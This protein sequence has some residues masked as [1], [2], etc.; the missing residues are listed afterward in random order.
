[1]NVVTGSTNNETLMIK[2]IQSAIGALADGM[3]GTQTMSDIACKFNA[4]CFPLTLEI[5]KKPVIIANDI[6]PIIKP[7]TGLS[8]FTNSINGS[9]T[10]GDGTPNSICVVDGI[11]KSSNASHAHYGY[12]E[13]VLYKTYDGIVDIKRVKSVTELP[14][15]I[16]WAVGGM[17]LQRFYDPNAEGF[18]LMPDGKRFDDV[19]RLTNHAMLGYKNNY[20]F[21]VLCT[22]MTGV[23]VNSFANLLGLELG[24][25]LDGGHIAGINGTESFAKINTLIMQNFMIQGI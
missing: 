8:G 4:K 5:Y 6:I 12:P 1:M 2:G 25:M 24:I 21:M 9:F 3:I 10:W 20:I 14:S 22:N 13:S 7:K 18:K 23:Q 17:G 19:L 16:K 15:N 11:V